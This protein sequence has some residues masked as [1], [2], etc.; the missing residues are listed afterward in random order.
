M[1]NLTLPSGKVIN[2]CTPAEMK[3]HL[4]KY[5][6]GQDKAKRTIC[7]AVYN[8]YKRLYLST[9]P[10]SSIKVDKSNVLIVGSTG[11]GKTYI[12]KTLAEFMGVPYFI[13]NATSLTKTGYAGDDVESLL[14]GL[15][16][17]ANNNI[18]EAECG[19]VFIDEIDKLASRNA[20]STRNGT[21][22]GCESV[23]QGLLKMIEGNKVAV[24]LNEQNNNIVSYIDTTNI[25]FVGSGSFAG[26][27]EDIKK[28][29]GENII[30]DDSEIMDYL[31]QKDL[32]KFGYIPEF[33]GR[34][35]VITNVKPLSKEDLVRI[36]REP[37]NNILDQYAAL[38]GVDG[39]K[40]KITEES[41]DIIAEA[42]LKL[43]TGARALRSIL[44]CIMEDYMFET[45]GTNTTVVQITCAYTKEKLDKRY[46]NI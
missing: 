45:P 32:Y 25:L 38:L 1:T 4:D 23:Q 36:M 21:D 41:L 8:H 5:I 27:E 24:H 43:K 6:I 44:E 19:I 9:R 26:I 20:A 17:A 13:G 29:L 16:N 39:I 28:R 10:D 46:K 34:F 11:C 18:R 35:P 7:T 30:Y 15:V 37:K 42:A 31:C 2:Q 3:A 33:I 40:F 22:P 14:V 12:I